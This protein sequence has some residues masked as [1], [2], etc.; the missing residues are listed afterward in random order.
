M[1]INIFKKSKG[2]S[3]KAKVKALLKTYKGLSPFEAKLRIKQLE[4]K[5][6]D[7]DFRSSDIEDINKV[8]IEL[9]ALYHLRQ[10]Q[11]HDEL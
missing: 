6:R 7:S 3:K 10:K 8:K 4:S 9:C 11:K 1:T 5:L 2:A